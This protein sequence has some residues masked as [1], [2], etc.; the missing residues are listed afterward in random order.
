MKRSVLIYGILMFS[1]GLSAQTEE[2]VSSAI[3]I[4][5]I[6]AN[7]VGLTAFPET[8]YVEIYNASDTVVPLS[9]WMFVYDNKSVAL[10]DTALP[11][12]AYAVLYRA[13]NS[14]FVESGGMDLPLAAFPAALANT[15]KVLKILNP[16]SE[17][18]DSIAYPAAKPAISYERNADGELYLSTDARGGTPGGTNSPET[19][20]AP[21]ETPDSSKVGDVI[22]TEIM[23]N[24]TGLTAFPET[25]YVE[26]YN[27]SDTAV[28][29]S[30]WTFVYDNKSVALP[31]TALPVGTYAVLYRAGNSIFV[32]SGG[33]DLPLATFPAALA[34]TGKTL[35]LLNSKG[36]IIDSIAYPAAKPAISYERNADGDLYLSTDARGGTPGAVNSPET[37]PAPPEKLDPSKAGDVLITEIMANPVGLT[38]YPETEYVEIYNASDS[39]VSLSGW[40]FVYDNKSVAL[41]DTTLPIGAYA[42]L[43]RVGNSIFVESGGIDLPLAAFPAALANTGKT[44]QILNSKGAII[45]SIAYPAAKPA[46]SYERNADG[47]LYLSTDARGGTPGTV[48]SPETPPTPPE[49]PDPSKAGDVLITEVMANPV[50]LTAFPETEYVEIHNVSG[51]A[52]EMSG[53][54]FVYD[55]K[56]VALPETTLPANAYAVIYRAGRS[57]FIG[58]GGIDM[59]VAT[60]PSALA[61]TG[62]TLQIVNSKGIVIDEVEYASAK[63]AISYERN[64]D[65][66]L[67]L[68]SD[69]RG[70]TPGTVNSPEV[71]SS[72]DNQKP[73]EPSVNPVPD[74][75]GF[76]DVI[77]SEIMAN[78]VGLTELPETEYIEI[79]NVT[80][81][82]LTL[83]SWSFIYDNRTIALPT[84]VLPAGSYAVLYREGREISVGSDG[85]AVAVATFPSALANTGKM[86]QIVN[87]AGIVIDSIAY[88]TA[89]PAVSYERNADGELYLSTD[90][91]GGTPGAANSPET[92]PVIPDEPV[93]TDNSQFGDLIINEIM[94]NPVGLTALPETEYVELFNATYSVISLKGWTFVYDK[95]NVSLPDT[96]LEAGQYAVIYRSGRE[97]FVEE[98]GMDLP[99]ATFPSALANTGK[100]LQIINSVGI[101]IDSIAYPAA[102]SAIS[103][104]RD[105]D[106]QLY[107]STDPRG[108]TP[109]AVNSEKTISRPENPLDQPDPKY[110]ET[111]V[112]IYA[113]EIIFNELLPEPYEGGSEYIELYNRSGHDLAVS[114]LTV[115]TRR[116][117]GSLGTKYTLPSI[118]DIVPAGGYIVLTSNK[119]GVLNYYNAPNPDVIYE[120][121]SPLLNNEASTLVLFNTKDES[122]VDEISY[123]SSW[124]DAAIKNKK[125]VSLERISPDKPTQDASNWTSALYTAGY[126]TPGYQNSQLPAASSVTVNPPEYNAATYE[127]SIRY[128]TD[129]TGYRCRIRIFTTEGIQVA[130][131]TNNQLI[132]ADGEIVWDGNGSN[133]S[134]LRPNVYIFLAELYH[135]DGHRYTFKKAFLARQ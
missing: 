131:I 49:K 75:S 116:A 78:P 65:G 3:V 25:E 132:G 92:P 82:E 32:E 50:G 57:I 5:E 30:G 73:D 91:R 55:G 89:K 45:D 70:G 9:G 66:D 19:P 18:V 61:N 8:E 40:T 102:T 31:D 71:T 93:N 79:Y 88:P 130:E 118:A 119:E 64:A 106:G 72:P 37:P 10:P 135:P 108:G 111:G 34:N 15:G 48:N 60:F 53:W 101:I 94:A 87:S 86:L 14:I 80:D 107:L 2:T 4:S 35:Q 7:P 68:S 16:E 120:M 56:A 112:W 103:Y 110:P 96:L 41:P 17:T 43:Y 83:N 105:D 69:P 29:L 44:L 28:S 52:I 58:V 39:A 21:P 54:T 98:G 90:P 13:G 67:Y 6:M 76:G 99:V 117:D 113:D 122:I 26:I 84:I 20:P 33:I 81:R 115:S 104:E 126:G 12:G 74:N 127:Y 134:R 128:T 109:G 114:G 38:A 95:T 124:H 97:I 62:K 36:A 11:V 77:I 42:V 121:R 85:L 63:A 24:P 47:D 1:L 46:I 125:G 27:A 59:P 100:T 133:G 129:R 23:A 123:S 22:I 51:S